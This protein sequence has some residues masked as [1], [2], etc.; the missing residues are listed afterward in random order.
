[1]KMNER[2]LGFEVFDDK[3]SV[4]GAGWR[5]QG[6][7][8]FKMTNGE[9]DLGIFEEKLRPLR[10]LFLRAL[11]QKKELERRIKRKGF[12]EPLWDE[13]QHILE[14]FDPERPLRVLGPYWQ[15]ELESA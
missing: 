3:S 1:M 10:E 5:E 12:P 8:M 15:R 11:A 9:R 6:K 7:K 2:A 4:K 13:T 14:E